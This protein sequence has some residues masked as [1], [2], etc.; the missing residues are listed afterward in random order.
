MLRSLIGSCHPQPVV[1]VTLVAVL[2]AVG[3][4][5]STFGVAAVGIAVLSGQLAV[6]WH[7]DWFD[8]ERDEQA[9]RRDKPLATGGLRR[10]TVGVAWGV[11]LVACIPLSLLSGWKA[12]LAHLAGVGL[13]LGYNIRLKSSVWS[14]VPYALAFALLAA[15]IALG[16]RPD[17]VPP[18][19]ALLAGAL[20]GVGAH[21]ANTVPDLE[22]DAATGVRGLPH[23]LGRNLSV[24]SAAT[25][26]LAASAL[27][28]FG[29]GRPG[30]IV[31]GLGAAVV[32]VGAGLVAG[33][34]HPG[35]LF[36]SAM[37]VALID[38]VMLIARGRQL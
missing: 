35:L 17:A 22:L 8:A 4:G 9:G 24:A 31:V 1:A 21:L 38:V 23:I 16:R 10:E 12:A 3:T 27:V 32:V 33:R 18:W 30:W 20:L 34:R 14:W 5:R 13:A 19:W 26:L 7:N 11:A 37:V 25:L 6:G 36:R 15:F 28:A 29:P 2:L